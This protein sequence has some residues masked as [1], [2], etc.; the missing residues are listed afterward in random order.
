[1]PLSSDLVPPSLHPP[2]VELTQGVFG[3]LYG[4]FGVGEFELCGPMRSF[5]GG[6]FLLR[7][8]QLTQRFGLTAR[9]GLGI[10]VRH[11]RAIG[12]LDQLDS[13]ED[14]TPPRRQLVFDFGML[15]LGSRPGWHLNRPQ[16]STRADLRNADP[17]SR[18]ESTVRKRTYQ[19]TVANGQRPS[20]INKSGLQRGM[21]FRQHGRSQAYAGFIGIGPG[22]LHQIGDQVP[23]LFGQGA[24]LGTG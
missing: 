24:Q 12:Y 11:Q 17:W 3:G 6:K 13:P 9:R 4:R 23:A 21:N 7:L 18:P 5:D 19:P 16:L 2:R 10:L 22:P 14:C 20:K 8:M 15:D 1:M